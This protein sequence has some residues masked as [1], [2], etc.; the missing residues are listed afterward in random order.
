MVICENIVLGCLKTPTQTDDNPFQVKDW[1]TGGL[2][3]G[4]CTL[5][6]SMASSPPGV[7]MMRS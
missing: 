3:L 7:D 2:S 1:M 4:Y 5:S 6:L